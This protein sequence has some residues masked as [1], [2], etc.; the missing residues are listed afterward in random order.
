MNVTRDVVTDL[1][2]VYFSGEASADTRKLVEDYFRQDPDFE[3]NARRAATP[4]DTLKVAAWPGLL[5]QSAEAE[6]EKRDLEC[7]RS[8][9]FR[10]KIIFGL[11]LFFSL[12]P[13]AF[14]IERGH[15][16]WMMMRNAPWDAALYWTMAAILWIVYFVRLKQRTFSLIV[17][18][19]LTCFSA[20]DIGYLLLGGKLF[21]AASDRVDLVW[22]AALFGGI[23]ALA[24]ITYFALMRHRTRVLVGAIFLTLFPF[25]FLIYPTLASGPK[26]FGSMVEPAVIW[27][28][29]GFIWLRYFFLRSRARTDATC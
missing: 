10:K 4:L 8:T 9:L 17:G 25:P 20:F 23:A 15:I 1:L 27:S 7:V 6:K 2:P 24:W 11:A 26:I 29:A 19:F 14:V 21:P 13:F 16:A 12:A 28:I 22:E 5:P 3:R 18:I